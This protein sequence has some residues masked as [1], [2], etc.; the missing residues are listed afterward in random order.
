MKAALFL[1]CHKQ[2]EVSPKMST[3]PRPTSLLDDM[4]RHRANHT[5]PGN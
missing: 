1:C 5:L 3:D 2:E 4:L